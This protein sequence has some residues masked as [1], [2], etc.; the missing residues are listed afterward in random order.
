MARQRQT[1]GHR[2]TSK[3]VAQRWTATV[4]LLRRPQ[5]NSVACD[6]GRD[7]EFNK[8]RWRLAV[9]TEVDQHAQLVLHALFDG[10]PCSDKPG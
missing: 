5:T 8:I 4:G 10:Q 7:D 2:V 1:R 9:E 3:C 6:G